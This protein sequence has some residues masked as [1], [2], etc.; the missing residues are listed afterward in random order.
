M[1]Q[2]CFPNPVISNDEGTERVKY[3]PTGREIV[4]M[5]KDANGNEVEGLT[6][7]GELNKV[8]SNVLLGRSHIGVHWRMDGVYGA[9]M[10]ETSAV[11]RLQQ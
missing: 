2:R 9:L 8:S 7:E 1:G 6:Y 5:C 10:G 11:R 3:V 4:G